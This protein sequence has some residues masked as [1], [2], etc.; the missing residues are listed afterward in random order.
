M[1]II[2]YALTEEEKSTYFTIDYSKP[3]YVEAHKFSAHHRE[4]LEK[5]SKCG[6]F[7]CLSIFSPGQISEWIEDR[8]ETACCPYCFMDSVIGESSGYPI[9]KDF[10]AKM[11]KHWFG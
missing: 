9:T 8:G 3:D 7:Y 2:T 5:D 11:N 10:L 4:M 1:D 6:C